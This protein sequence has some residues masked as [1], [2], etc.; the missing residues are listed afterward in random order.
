MRFIAGLSYNIGVKD[1][2]NKLAQDASLLMSVNNLL[3]HH[4]HPKPKNMDK[5]LY[6]SGSKGC[7]SCNIGS[8]DYNINSENT[9]MASR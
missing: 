4:G 8:G 5:K 3:E 9:W 6:D 7:S 2:Y 1:E